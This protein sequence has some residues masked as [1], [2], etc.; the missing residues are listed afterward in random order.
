MCPNANHAQILFESFD[1]DASTRRVAPIGMRQNENKIIDLSNGV[2]DNSCCFGYAC[3]LRLTQN[4]INIECGKT[5]QYHT[6]GTLPKNTRFHM[7]GLKPKTQDCKARIELF[8]FRQNRQKIYLN[9][10]YV[11]LE[12]K[13]LINAI[14]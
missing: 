9:N 11:S 12:S 3:L 10:N 1:H 4:Y 2:L 7:F 13:M 8:T 14:A 6:S 5:Y